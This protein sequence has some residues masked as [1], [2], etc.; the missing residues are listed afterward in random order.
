MN[1]APAPVLQMWV[2]YRNAADF[3][4][5]VMAR[6]HH[7]EAGRTLPTDQTIVPQLKAGRRTLSADECRVLELIEVRDAIRRAMPG[8][9]RLDRDADDEPQIVE[10]WL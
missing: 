4:D 1:I 7:I 5:K 2:V 9:F 8:A 10:V 6:L 3:P